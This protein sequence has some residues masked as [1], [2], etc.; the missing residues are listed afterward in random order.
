MASVA[1]SHH[2]DDWQFV[3]EDLSYHWGRYRSGT[4]PVML[5]RIS[6]D[7]RCSVR[8]T[9]GAVT[10]ISLDVTAG[11]MLTARMLRSFPLGQAVEVARHHL[12]AVTEHIGE[13]YYASDEQRWLM[14]AAAEL[15]R[16]RISRSGMAVV[17]CLYCKA[18]AESRHPAT[19]L[20][21]RLGVMKQRIHAVLRQAERNG[22]LDR[23]HLP[24]RGV[25]GG[26][27]TSDATALLDS[28][29]DTWQA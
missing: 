1:R 16:K 27:L 21:E 4:G 12:A 25:A 18:A 2:L 10:G 17:A 15:Q 9:D 7:L 28:M 6:D 11:E 14:V 8:F 3:G 13:T 5:H 22:L 29:E 26:R 20:A 24:D 19:E 23:S